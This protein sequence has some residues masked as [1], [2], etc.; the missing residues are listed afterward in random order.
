MAILRGHVGF[1]RDIFA[2][3]GFLK[4]PFLMFGHQDLIGA[5]FPPDFRFKDVKE[6]LASQDIRNVTT[7][8]LF[9]E[10]ADWRFDLNNPVPDSHHETYA[11]VMD[12][13]SLEHL[14]DTAQVLE[15]C[16]RMVA[17]NGFYLLETPVNGCLRHGFHTFN[18]DMIIRTLEL[19]GFAVRYLKYISFF[20]VPIADPGD[21]EH[22]LMI[23]V[24]QKTRPLLTLT[25]PQQEG[26]KA[27]NEDMSRHKSTITD[28]ENWPRLEYWVFRLTPPVLVPLVHKIRS[29]ISNI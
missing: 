12:I 28:P 13:G 20:G 17:L 6:L 25:I 22:A 26:W 19:N 18:P 5:D 23:I 1:F 7:V 9:D 29:L 4:E 11:T 3:P 27:I 15:N 21:A 16:L 10:R 24:A 8:D 14:F 2:I